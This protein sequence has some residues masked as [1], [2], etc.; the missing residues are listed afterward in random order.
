MRLVESFPILLIDDE[1][2][3]DTAAG[4]A[5]RALVDHLRADG[6]RV[7]TATDP[8]DATQ[9]I[10]STASLSCVL[11]DWDG[12]HEPASGHDRCDPMVGTA[13]RADGLVRLVR[14]RNG[15]VPIFLL[16]DRST[17]EDLP[18]EVLRIVTG[19]VWKLEDTPQFVADR[20]EEARREYLA[21]LLPPFFGALVEFVQEARYSW[22]TPGHSGGAAFL[23]TPVGSAFH[24]FFGENMLRSDLSVSVEELGSL[25][26]HSGPVGAAEAEAAKTFGAD[27]T[28]FVTNGTSTANRI[29]FCACARRGDVVLVDRN[30][31]KSIMHAIVMTGAI[32]VYLHPTRNAYGIIGPIPPAGLGADSVRASLAANPLVPAGTTT[33]AL[34]VIT[35]ST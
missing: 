25:L 7:I 26:E 1:L 6:T 35:N 4:R 8:D 28:M 23:K 13:G 16:A 33:A 5:T 10:G 3:D 18:T 24:E 21:P 14:E 30:C 2:D 22:H 17:A 9:I 34:A 29:V 32:P 12:H 15:A 31:H 11:I 19:Y 20:V 27:R